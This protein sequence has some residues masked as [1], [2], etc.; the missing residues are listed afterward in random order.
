MEEFV[1]YILYSKKYHKIYIGYSSSLIQRFYSHNHF[2]NKGYT[3]K[4]RPWLVL[5]VEF[6]K[7]KKQ[8]MQRENFLK[9]GKGREYIYKTVFPKYTADGFI[10]A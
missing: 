6:H 7:T 8:A 1:T 10:S 9:S 5:E 2:S 4:Y 3:L